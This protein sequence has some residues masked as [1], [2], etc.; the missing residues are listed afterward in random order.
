[1][2]K[3]DLSIIIISYNTR[4]YLDRCLNSI[5][6]SLKNSTL[7][8]EVIVVDNGSTDGSQEMVQKMYPRV[9]LMK[10]QTNVGFGKANNQGVKVAQGNIL[11][12]LNSDIEVQNQAIARLYEYFKALPIKSVV[13]G[14]LFNVDGSAQPSCGPAYT[15]LVIFTALFL[16]GDHLHVTRYSPMMVKR[17]D[18]IMGA[19]MM[20]SRNA[21]SDVGGF[22]E[23]IYMYME[24]IDWQHRARKSGYQIY[25]YP[26][27][28]FTHVGAGSSG[29][30]TTPILNVYRGLI[31]YYNKY[32]NNYKKYILR[33]ILILKAVIAIGIFTILNKK[34]DQKLYWE[35]L[36]LALA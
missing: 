9:K 18:W 24:E 33:V 1:M 31:F 30:R 5:F 12:L 26:N 32:Y 10:N 29:S 15:L 7:Q 4:Q 2:K 21:M 11:L 14:K 8:Y 35:A 34:D 20:L 28:H 17:V 36:K 3:I 22:D 25:F 16:K 27:S 19:C 13:G 6:Q 23:D